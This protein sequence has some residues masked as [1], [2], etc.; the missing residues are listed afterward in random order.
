MCLYWTTPTLPRPYGGHA[1]CRAV[2]HLAT[3][4]PNWRDSFTV[5]L[6]GANLATSLPATLRLTAYSLRLSTTAGRGRGMDSIFV[7]RD[8]FP[9]A[10]P[11]CDEQKRGR[12]NRTLFLS[13][14]A[15]DNATH[16]TRRERIL[17]IALFAY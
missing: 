7:Y 1:N 12:S 8:R 3:H 9:I 6:E 4:P 5:A 17:I 13:F 16:A 2:A 11:L 15:A 14:A 10:S